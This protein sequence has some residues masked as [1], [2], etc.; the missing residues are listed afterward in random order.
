MR[1]PPPPPPPPSQASP[2]VRFRPD[3]PRQPELRRQLEERQRQPSL[4]EMDIFEQQ[5][6]NK[7]QPQVRDKFKEWYNW[8]VNH[9]PKPIKE[10]ASRAF[11][12]AKDKIMGFYKGLGVKMK[13]RLTP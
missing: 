10:Q 9:V 1:P 8:L 11:K 5:E 13:N 6:M 2:S 3:R 7:S 4:Q 12:A